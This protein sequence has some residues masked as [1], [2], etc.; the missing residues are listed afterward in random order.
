MASISPRPGGRFQAQIRTKGFKPMSRVFDTKAEAVAWAKAVEVDQ[1]RGVIKPWSSVELTVKEAFERYLETVTV[2]KKGAKQEG[3]RARAFIVDCGFA[4]ERLGS[5]KG[6]AV[7]E[8]VNKRL[9]RDKVSGSTVNRGLAL[10]SHVYEVASKAWGIEG[11][12]N[13]VKRIVKPKENKAR[14]RRVNLLPGGVSELDLILAKVGNERLRLVYRLLIELA[15]RRGELLKLRWVDVNLSDRWVRFED[16]KNGESRVVPLSL[17]AV[18]LLEAMRR[19]GNGFGLVVG[20]SPDYVS[21]AWRL[22]CAKAGVKGLRLHDTRREGVSRL[23]EDVGLGTLE[24]AAISGHKTVGMLKRYS[25]FRQSNLLAKLDAAGQASQ[26]T[27]MATTSPG[28]AC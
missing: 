5:V 18:G 28:A 26:A 14:D 16:T 17:V 19:G 25:A 27:A 9:K 10:L 6:V 21:G 7:A 8:Y 2:T 1:A 12:E 20:L 23:F 24:V 15:C 11:L 3:N 13:P 22:A 4:N